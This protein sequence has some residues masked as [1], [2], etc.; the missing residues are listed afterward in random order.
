[1]TAYAL[2]LLGLMLGFAAGL[3]HFAT[4]RKVTALYLTGGAPGRALA[5]QLARLVLLTALLAGLAL[6]GAG[7]LLAGALGV[8]LARAVILRR[9]GKEA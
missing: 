9:A 4:L 3:A 6:L 2:S 1:M 8:V 7:P 5:L